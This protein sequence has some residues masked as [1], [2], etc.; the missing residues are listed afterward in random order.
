[1]L[2]RAS[3][4][5]FPA[6]LLLAPAT[7]I[8]LVAWEASAAQRSA[9]AFV[10]GQMVRRPY[11]TLRLER[12]NRPTRHIFAFRADAAGADEIAIRDRDELIHSCSAADVLSDPAPLLDDL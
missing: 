6:V 10:A 12:P 8:F 5:T 11:A 9:T 4:A 2:I 7:G 1:M 3:D